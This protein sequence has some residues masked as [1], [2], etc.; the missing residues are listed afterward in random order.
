MALTISTGF[1]VDD[2]I[3]VLENITRHVEA[4]M[5]RRE[6]ALLG[7]REV[8]F[9]VLSMS[10]S[11]IAVFV[12]ILLMGGLVGRIFREF[13]MTLSVAILISLVVSLTTTPM[14]CAYIATHRPQ[15][16]QSRLNRLGERAFDAMLG[17][18]DRTLRSALRRPG[19]V[20]LILL[21]TVILNVYLFIIVPK[22]LF[23]QQDTGRMIGGI[24][25]DQSISF[26]L[27]RE[28]LKEFV[29][30]VGQD[31][32][33]A[34]VVGFTGGGQTNSGFMFVALKPLAE[35]DASVSQV[36]ARLRG[37]LAQ[38]PGAR[39]FLQPVQDIRVGG[40]QSNALYQYTLQS[41]DLNELYSWVP[42]VTAALEQLPELTEVNS[43][44]QQKGLET[45]LVIDRKTAA[46]FGL[47]AAQID[48]TLYDAFGQR[49]SR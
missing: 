7:A 38:V 44:Q 2:A 20:M 34:N 23:P 3:V 28:K 31:P 25:A 35:R 40:R 12:P 37:K 43:D 9:T 32:A 8:G 22:G 26:Q 16:R 17:F 18:Y 1:V 10:L 48:N 45:D 27:M 11:L 24:Q 30:I 13:A 14:M 46:R 39:L 49:K 15:Q 5:P 29:K 41:D 47:T 19:L 4:G 33:A 6:A 36:M 42:K 21:L